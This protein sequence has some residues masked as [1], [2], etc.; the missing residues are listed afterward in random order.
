MRTSADL[1]L[2]LVSKHSLHH[3]LARLLLPLSRIS[4]APTHHA[5]HPSI[6]VDMDYSNLGRLAYRLKPKTAEDRAEEQRQ[7]RDLEE[8]QKELD[9]RLGPNPE[10][11]RRA[12]KLRKTIVKEEPNDESQYSPWLI[13]D[14]GLDDVDTGGDWEQ[15]Y[16]TEGNPVPSPA[17]AKTEAEI[18]QEEEDFEAAYPEHPI[19]IRDDDDEYAPSETVA[20]LLDANSTAAVQTFNLPGLGVGLAFRPATDLNGLTRWQPDEISS[21]NPPTGFVQAGAAAA[22]PLESAKER[23]M[24]V[25]ETPMPTTKTTQ[26]TNEGLF[27][28]QDHGFG[29]ASTTQLRKCG[30]DGERAP[31]VCFEGVLLNHPHHHLLS[32]GDTVQTTDVVGCGSNCKQSIVFDGKPRGRPIECSEDKCRREAKAFASLFIPPKNGRPTARSATPSHVYNLDSEAD[33]RRFAEKNQETIDQLGGL[34]MNEA[35][36]NRGYGRSRKASRSDRKRSA[37]PPNVRTRSYRMRDPL[38][39]P[40]PNPEDEAERM[41]LAR[42]NAAK[43]NRMPASSALSALTPRERANLTV[44]GKDKLMGAPA[45]PKR[46]QQLQDSMEGVLMPQAPVTQRS[47]ELEMLKVAGTPALAMSLENAQQQGPWKVAN[48]EEMKKPDSKPWSMA[49]GGIRNHEAGMIGMKE[50]TYVEMIQ[51]ED[52]VIIEEEDTGSDRL[53]RLYGRFAKDNTHESLADQDVQR[54]NGDMDLAETHCIC[55]NPADGFMLPCSRCDKSFH[56]HC[57]GKGQNAKEAYEGEERMELLRAD[58]DTINADDS[59][60]FTCQACDENAALAQRMLGDAARKLKKGGSVL[61]DLRRQGTAEAKAMDLTRKKLNAA[62]EKRRNGAL[63]GEDADD[64][65]DGEVLSLPGDIPNILRKVADRKSRVSKSTRPRRTFAP[66]VPAKDNIKASIIST[67]ADI[68]AAQALNDAADS[69]LK[70]HICRK[71]IYGVHF[72]CLKC[73]DSQIDVCNACVEKGASHIS[74]KHEFEVRHASGPVQVAPRMAPLEAGLVAEEAEALEAE[75]T[76]EL[77]VEMGD[78]PVVKPPSAAPPNPYA[79][80]HLQ[81]PSAKSTVP[82]KPQ[83]RAVTSGAGTRTESPAKLA[84][85][86]GGDVEMVDT[87]GSQGRSSTL[88]GRTLR[89]RALVVTSARTVSME[90]NDEDVVL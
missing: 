50:D 78:A 84:A 47:R 55:E 5:L 22:R 37:S 28:P 52:G 31:T 3:H 35:F 68:A 61:R 58:I 25:E 39:S 74:T 32:C 13:E 59:A 82:R 7:L 66:A 60:D 49:K 67:P 15:V 24:P 40:E 16:D 34:I 85:A 83:S 42:L 20:P 80:A 88:S 43:G 87:S 72:H 29:A 81:P 53:V 33:I 77:D 41:L 63:F 44:I 12:E 19:I 17:K 14:D 38:P 56:P 73:K 70:C 48:A 8:N 26:P 69:K 62:A 18:R 10:R 1:N 71:S 79:N 23:P 86:E 4:A 51:A 75:N 2:S 54:A 89:P 27:I 90:D 30:A 9:E 21:S 11:Q 57:I 76:G 36:N 64:D 6:V 65:S 46:V 45:R